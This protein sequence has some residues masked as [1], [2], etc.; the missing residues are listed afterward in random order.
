[1]MSKIQ[2][3]NYYGQLILDL[4]NKAHVGNDFSEAVFFDFAMSVLIEDGHATESEE[5]GSGYKYTPFRHTGM[6]VDG[7]EY[8]PDRGIIRI[9]I[10]H[11]NQE[12]T[13]QSLTQTELDQ[14]VRN[15]KRFFEK[16]LT[17]AFIHSLEESSEAYEIAAFINRNRT[18]FAQL[19]V[20]IISNAVLSKKISSLILSKDGWFDQIETNLDVWDLQRFYDNERSKGVSES[21]EIDF[22]DEFGHGVTALPAHIQSSQYKSYLLA[23][24]GEVLA[25]LYKRYGARLLEANVRSFLQFKGKVNK[26]I[27]QTIRENPEMFFAYNNGITAT[28]DECRVNEAGEIVYLK[29]LQ[30]VNGGQTTAS[31][32]QTKKQ[33]GLSLEK[34]F[35]QTK[36]S[37]VSN[38]LVDELVPNISR[39]ANTQ[40]KISDSDFF[41]NH[42]FHR[43]MQEISRRLVAP[44]QSGQIRDSKWF[45]ERARG[46]YQDELSKRTQAEK[47]IFQLEYPKIQVVTKTDLAKTSVIFEGKPNHA[48]KGAQIAFKY[49]A[50]NV[51]ERWE[52][53]DVDFND[54]F[55]K[56]LIAKQLIFTAAREIVLETIV[57]NGIQP[58]I[59]YTV[60]A[61]SKLV[62][63]SGEVIDFQKIWER[64][65]LS[66]NMS[67]LIKR[68]VE[69]TANFFESEVAANGRTVLSYSKSDECLRRFDQ[70]LKESELLIDPISIDLI[71][72]QDDMSIKRAAKSDRAIDNEIDLLRA[73]LELSSGP[74]LWDAAISYGTEHALLSPN[75]SGILLVMSKFLRG[76][77]QPS[78]KQLK[79]IHGIL[80]RLQFEGF[81]V[82]SF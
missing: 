67:I 12:T 73:L 9:Y 46:Q 56:E 77:R 50:D 26:G 81:D 80:V 35:V 74:T 6:R 25:R 70:A 79:A 48:V 65:A 36:L 76:G 21:I 42:P 32:F 5:S 1:M 13:P 41:S 37:V 63:D 33:D 57:G 61:L 17:T 2:L 4:R 27:R 30:I 38:D 68:V 7:Y 71:S 49:F 60:Y 82:K 10:A 14:L 8:I 15:S 19:D 78:F 69:Y 75:E 52:R 29:N 62:G 45:Y 3:E 31:L 66:S 28:A 40:N 58:T 53:R 59:A 51:V 44:R 34:V 55:F 11:F 22:V 39:F 16:S 72:K 18:D 24:P 20:V 64:Q 23:L 54:A 43:R 47:N